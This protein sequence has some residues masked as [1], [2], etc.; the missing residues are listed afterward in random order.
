[1]IHNA[2]HIQIHHY[3]REGNQAVNFI[4]TKDRFKFFYFGVFRAIV[5]KDDLGCLCG[6]KNTQ[7]LR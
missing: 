3:F 1:M 4:A 7:V 5:L 6:R 2:D